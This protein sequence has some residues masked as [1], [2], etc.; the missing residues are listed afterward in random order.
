MASKALFLLGF[1]TLL[2]LV[3]ELVGASESQSGNVKWGSEETIQTN[4]DGGDGGRGGYK[5][6]LNGV[7][8]GGPSVGYNRKGHWGYR[9]SGCPHGC[10][11]QIIGCFRCCK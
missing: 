8:K 6:E 5:G 2:L 3:S 1:F 10:C 11:L 9:Y 7:E 4:H